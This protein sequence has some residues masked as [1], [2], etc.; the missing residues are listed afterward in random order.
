M[1]LNARDRRP[2]NR[3]RGRLIVDFAGDGD[4]DQHPPAAA[5]A[6][7]RSTAERLDEH[8][9]LPCTRDAAP[10]YLDGSV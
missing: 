6:F 3:P 5:H 9:N 2:V 4:H 10:V 1:T 8:D 7:L